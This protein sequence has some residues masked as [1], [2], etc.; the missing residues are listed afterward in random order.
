MYTFCL[1]LKIRPTM[2]YE[3]VK[4]VCKVISSLVKKNAAC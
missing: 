1:K 2:L 3:D 4:V